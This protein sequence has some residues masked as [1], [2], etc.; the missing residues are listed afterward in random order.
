MGVY[1]GNS[2]VF[3]NDWIRMF[4]LYLKTKQR[5]GIVLGDG[6]D[7][8]CSQSTIGTWDEWSPWPRIPRESD[9]HMSRWIRPW[10]LG[11]ATPW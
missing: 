10:H 1:D 2:Y 6:G 9:G 3:G 4:V 11:T 7:D 8:G 5:I